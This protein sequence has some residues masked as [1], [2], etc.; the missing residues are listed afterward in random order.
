MFPL[1]NVTDGIGLGNGQAGRYFCW[2]R[3]C[4]NPHSGLTSAPA[5]VFVHGYALS[6]GPDQNGRACLLSTPP[7]V[8]PVR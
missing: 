7:P 4:L 5:S 6:S 1:G 3:A 8:I 2:L